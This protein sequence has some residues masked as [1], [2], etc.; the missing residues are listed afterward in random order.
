MPSAQVLGILAGL[1]LCGSA[2]AQTGQPPSSSAPAQTSPTPGQAGWTTA[3]A[4]AEVKFVDVQPLTS[5]R[6]S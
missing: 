4:T 3:A 2:F 6:R 5:W 1:I